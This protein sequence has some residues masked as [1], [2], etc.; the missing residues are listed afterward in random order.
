MTITKEAFLKL[1]TEWCYLEAPQ[2]EFYEMVLA[3]DNEPQYKAA[4]E[5][6]KRERDELMMVAKVALSRNV[7]DMELRPAVAAVIFNIEQA[8][9]DAGGGL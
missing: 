5:K 9:A 4:Y 2:E 3:R 1:W 7:L 6:V 8:E